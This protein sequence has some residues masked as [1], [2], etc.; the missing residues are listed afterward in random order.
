[1]IPIAVPNL[2]G[3]EAAYLAQC[4]AENFVSS[5]GAFVTRFEEMVAEA[6]G[7]PGAVA[8]SSGTTALHTALATLGVG[9][10]DLVILQ[11]MTFIGSANAINQ[12]GARPWLMDVTGE[13]WTLDPQQL[14]AAL[15]TRTRRDGDGTLRHIET[16]ARVAA[17]M[18]VYTMGTPAD[19]P[20]IAPV[21][22]RYGLPIV[23][24]AAAAIG[25]SLDGRTLADMGADISCISFNGNKT[26]TCGGG[27]AVISA[28]PELLKRAR[29][30]S[31]TARTGR[32]YDHDVAGF[33]YRMTNIQ[34]AVGVA[35]MENLAPFL[36]R[37]RQIAARYKDRLTGH[38]LLTA[39][40]DPN[41]AQGTFWF[42][43]VVLDRAIGDRLPEI[44]EHLRAN[45]IDARLFWKPMHL[46]TPYAD[47]PREPL[48]VTDDVWQRVLVLPCSTSLTEAEQE[49][50]MSAV[51]AA[52]ALQVERAR[53]IA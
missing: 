19:M 21:A 17:I 5:V 16:G 33:N 48:P 34:A 22:R 46:Q 38:P 40:P 51:L 8:T 3:N 10:G 52:P 7:A 49:H 28:D 32:N 1:M 35:Q 11:A 25:A 12:A 42:S 39:F 41:Y 36:E 50:V 31:T 20:A 18:P 4:V 23:A 29:H 9:H 30:L 45:D 37:K 47:C 14:E 24:D 6:T 27:G 15:G 13:S 53:S 2:A 43:G 44:I 26:V